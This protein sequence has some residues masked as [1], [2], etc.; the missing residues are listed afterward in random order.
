MGYR[1][2]EQLVV[3]QEFPIAKSLEP[4]APSFVVKNSFVTHPRQT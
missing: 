2:S 3:S 1:L 4:I